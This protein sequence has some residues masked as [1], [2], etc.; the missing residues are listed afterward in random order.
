MEREWN[1]W[2]ADQQTAG[3]A[4]MNE[5]LGTPV[6]AEEIEDD[7]LPDAVDTLDTAA[8]E[9]LCDL[10]RWCFEGLGLVAGPDVG[11]ALTVDAGVDAVGDGLHLGEFRHATSL[12][13]LKQIESISRC[14]RA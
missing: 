2:G 12:L 14:N 5:K 3:H 13:G 6:V 4:E 10:G 7:G 8:G 1:F 11:D 9:D